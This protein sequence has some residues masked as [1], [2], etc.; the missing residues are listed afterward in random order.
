MSWL[1][2]QGRNQMVVIKKCR[3]C[4]GYGYLDGTHRCPACKGTGRAKTM[5][6]RIR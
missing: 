5:V 6:G 1:R 3:H 4:K 2:R